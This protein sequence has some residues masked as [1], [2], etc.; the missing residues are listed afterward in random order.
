MQKWIVLAAGVILQMVL[1]SVYAWSAF[2]PF[3]KSDHG[4]SSSECSLIFGVTIAT[5]TV[6]MIP[7]GRMLGRYGARPVAA[8]GSV[9]FFLGYLIAS[10]SGGSYPVILTGIGLITGMGIGA[11]Y[12]CPLTVGM[13][14][15]P[16][17][18]GLVTGVA[19]AGFGGGAIVLSS[20][21]EYMLDMHDGDV[22]MSFRVLGLALGGVAF[23]ASMFM[24]E[25]KS[26]VK[27]QA[28]AVKTMSIGPYLATRS[29]WLLCLGMFAGTFAGLLTIANLHPLI[30]N[31]GFNNMVATLGI[32]TFALGNSLGR[33]LWGQF[34]DKYGSSKILII[35]TLWL[36]ISL[37]PLTFSQSSSG[38]LLVMTTAAGMGFGGCFVVYASC[39]VQRYGTDFFPRLYPICFLGYGFAGL[40][41]PVIGGA[42]ADA[43][44]SFNWGIWL[45]V[46]LVIVVLIIRLAINYFEQK[47]NA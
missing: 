15:F 4:L 1:G 38:M 33:I 16:D 41:G 37:L 18:K 29:F 6:V 40:V 46:F 19:V 34:A 36:A 47:R 9:L 26:L 27:C 39:I 10:F 25:P 13:K 12:V 14:W 20:L 21:V 28:S 17:N 35:S 32:S 30:H 42:I 44:G 24:S 11:G 23:L 8:T 31:M 5:F 43:T 22:L 7:A 45:G 2:V 3:L